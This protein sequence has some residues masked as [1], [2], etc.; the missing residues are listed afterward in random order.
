MDSGPE[1]SS[2]CWKLVISRRIS[3]C[4]RSETVEFTLDVRQLVL[5]LYP[6]LGVVRKW[7]AVLTE[8]GVNLAS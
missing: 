2:C 8:D 5:A 7:L 6:R 4:N 3:G 1:M